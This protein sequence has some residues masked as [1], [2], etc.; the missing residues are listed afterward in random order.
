MMLKALPLQKG[1]GAI[2]IVDPR[3]KSWSQNKSGPRKLNTQVRLRSGDLNL[4][5]LKVEMEIWQG[6]FRAFD[7][8]HLG[9]AKVDNQ[10]LKIIKFG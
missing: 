3:L 2:S 7:D 8:H 1:Q 10:L 5:G 4:V 9:F 6:T